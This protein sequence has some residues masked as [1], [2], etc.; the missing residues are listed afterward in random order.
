MTIDQPS[1]GQGVEPNVD[2]NIHDS[3]GPLGSCLGRAGC[4][5]SPPPLPVG[6]SGNLNQEAPCYCPVVGGITLDLIYHLEHHSEESRRFSSIQPPQPSLHIRANRDSLLAGI[7]T[8]FRGIA[9]LGRR[10]RFCSIGSVGRDLG[11]QRIRSGPTYHQYELGRGIHHHHD[12]FYHW[13]G[14]RW[15]WERDMAPRCLG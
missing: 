12:S 11:P 10:L 5:V 13:S 7:F 2:R 15:P 14:V 9:V 3:L 1:S 8:T 6:R 4:R